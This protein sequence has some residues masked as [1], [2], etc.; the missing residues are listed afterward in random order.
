MCAASIT[1]DQLFEKKKALDREKRKRQK[2]LQAT[3]AA[4]LKELADKRAGQKSAEIH[5]R[6]SI[7][8]T[9]TNKDRAVEDEFR[10]LVAEMSEIGFTNSSQVSEYITRNRLGNKYKN[11]SGKLEMIM[12]D[13]VWDFDGGFPPKIY[14][15][16]CKELGLRNQGSKAVPGKFTPYKDIYKN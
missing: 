11:I 16:L 15:R 5:N 1:A 2:E 6:K 3:E 9:S 7:V 10:E 4:R 8:E 14:A 13:N 12:E